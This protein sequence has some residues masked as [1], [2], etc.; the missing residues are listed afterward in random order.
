MRTSALFDAKII[1]FFEIYGLSLQTR[2]RRLSQCRNFADKGERDQ[3][4]AILCGRP[5][6]TFPYHYYAIAYGCSER[7]YND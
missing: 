7:G 4:F 2:G 3:F 5:L 1:G 6:W